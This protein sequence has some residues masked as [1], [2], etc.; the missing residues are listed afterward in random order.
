M[1][2]HEAAMMAEP[3]GR[4]LARMD[5]GT[6]ELIEKY[7]DPIILL[8]GFATW[9]MRVWDVMQRKNDDRG[10]RKPPPEVAPPEKGNGRSLS[11]EVPPASPPT[12][13]LSRVDA[14]HAEIRPAQK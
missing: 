5:P 4:I 1:E 8:F 9:G 11:S 6:T 13:L 7:S 14:G 10:P 3:M 2:P 12:D